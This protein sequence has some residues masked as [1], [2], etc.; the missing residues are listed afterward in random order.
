[1][2]VW[3]IACATV[4]QIVFAAGAAGWVLLRREEVMGKQGRGEGMAM[5][6]GGGGGKGEGKKEL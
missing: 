3:G 4:V 2:Q 6:V 1:M 5:G